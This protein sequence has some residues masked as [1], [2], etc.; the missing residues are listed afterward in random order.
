MYKIPDIK[1]KRKDNLAGFSGLSPYTIRFRARDVKT[2]WSWMYKRKYIKHNPLADFVLPGVP[3]K[4]VRTITP[5][6]FRIIVSNIDTSTPSG[7]MYYC[8]M[9]IFYDNGVRLSELRTICVEDI[10][11]QGKSIK[12]MGKGHRE[13]LVPITVDTR[14][15]IRNY[16]VGIRP[17]LCFEKSP[18][19]FADSKGKPITKNSIEQFMMRLVKKAGLEGV[20][21]SPHI[22][23][24]SFATEYLANGGNIYYLQAILEH[25]S[26]V[27]TRRY[28]Q[29]RQQDVQEHH[30]RFSPVA[31]LSRQRL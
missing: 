31:Q 24:H 18:Y 12:V 16:I 30:S 11:F 27:M 9:H 25:R 19:L 8:I 2:L 14:R 10:D 6:Q 7:S 5:G 21:L 23:R 4:I 22:L 28:T 17:R 3:D 20:K 29:V 1:P 15:Y 26:P 13:R